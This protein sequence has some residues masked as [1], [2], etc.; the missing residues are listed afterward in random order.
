FVFGANHIDWEKGSIHGYFFHD[1]G[2]VTFE[3]PFPNVIY[4]RLPN[5]RTEKH[6]KIKQVKQKLHDEYLIPWF[7]PGFFNK[8]EIHQQ[9]MKHEHVSTYLPE[10]HTNISFSLIEQMLSNYQHVYVKP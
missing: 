9:L 7:N 6:L 1:N 8:W 3:V 4:D 2:W 10:T 5:R